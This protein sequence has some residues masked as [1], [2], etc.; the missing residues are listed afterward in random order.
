MKWVVLGRHGHV[1]GNTVVFEWTVQRGEFTHSR[2]R[3]SSLTA[4]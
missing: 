1:H 3:E 2:V 4:E